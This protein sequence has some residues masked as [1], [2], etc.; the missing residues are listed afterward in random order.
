MG[1]AAAGRGNGAGPGGLR[2][3]GKAAPAACAGQ[4]GRT[5]RAPIPG[6]PW[7]LAGVGALALA[8]APALSG[9]AAAVPRLG[10]LAILADA[11]HVLAAGGWI[12]GLLVLV[13]AGIPAAMRLERD[14][15]G[16]AVAA[17]VNAFS[18]T[19]LAFAGTL[20]L[21]GL[22]AAWLHMGS[23]PAL[24]ESGYGRTLLVK[25]GVLSGVFATG[26]Y[27]W[28][29]VRPALGDEL[30]ATRLRRSARVEIAIG[31]LV[32]LVTAVLVATAPSMAP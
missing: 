1:M 17:L 13:A 19:A 18:P 10:P 30:G 3:G 4:G 20:M 6:A 32:L 23:V 21:T 26:A 16:P 22:F 27:N 8:F 9:H 12:G 7:L 2:G 25:L 31:A 5:C 29:K 24:W 15:R 11:L 28:L 14:E